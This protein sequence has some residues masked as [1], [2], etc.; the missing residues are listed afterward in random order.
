MQHG[1][2]TRLRSYAPD[3]ATPQCKLL[4]F[5]GLQCSAET[6]LC[7]RACVVGE[8][9]SLH[10]LTCV[11]C[12]H[13]PCCPTLTVVCALLCMDAPGM[14]FA[15]SPAQTTRWHCWGTPWSAGCSGASAKTP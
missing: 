12:T 11:Q 5:S 10:K 4:P 7:Q 2:H 9:A 3:T 8:T 14:T 15:P 13:L 6:W 1:L